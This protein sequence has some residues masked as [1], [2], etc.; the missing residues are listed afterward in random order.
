MKVE[1]FV[2]WQ[3]TEKTDFYVSMSKN[4]IVQE[5]ISG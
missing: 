3:Q 1:F 2:M 4:P 5:K